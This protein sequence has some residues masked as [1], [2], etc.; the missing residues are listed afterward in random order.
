MTTPSFSPSRPCRLADVPRWDGEAD[1]LI[2]GFGMAGACAALEAARAGARCHMFELSAGPGGSTAMSGGEIYIGGGGG[3][4]VQRAAGFEDSTEDFFKYMMLAGGPNVDE[5]RVR[6]YAENALA[7]YEWL[8]AQGIPFKGTF[9]ASRTVEPLTDDTLVWS[10]S[11]AAWP[12]CEQA[13]P[14]PRGHAAQKKGMGAGK[15]IMER[16]AER[17]AEL[18]LIQTDF[19][20]RA[21]ALI[22]DADNRVQGLVVRIDGEAR[23][24]RAK[25]GVILCNGGFISNEDML[26]R[27]APDALRIK[28]QVST[29]ND[30]G[31]GIRMGLSVGAAAVQMHEVLSTRPFLPPEQLIKGIFVNQRGQ[32]FINEDAYHGRIGQYIMRQPSGEAWLLLDNAIFERPMLNPGVEVAAVG[33]SWAE[34][35][36]ALNIPAGELVHT[37]DTYNRHAAAGGD[38]MFHKQPEWLKPLDEPP[39]A[40][41][42]VGDSAWPAAGFTLGGLATLTTG[43]VI[44]AEGAVIP[45][46]YAAGRTSCGLPCWGEGYSSGLSLADASFFGRQA[47]RHLAQS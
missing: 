7:H 35:E 39:Y 5:A 29:G 12:F 32:R 38:P 19:N 3:T 13:K 31:S 16:L 1:V 14:A 30:D 21:L 27:Y 41:L 45:G 11:E 40:A 26:R 24:F 36:E 42:A 28:I 46:L 44:D 37:V 2:V 17:V 47:G 22:A 6:L 10:G 4:P 34:I 43:Q 9:H 20:A 25:K 18:P 8:V 23:F 33:E 15:I